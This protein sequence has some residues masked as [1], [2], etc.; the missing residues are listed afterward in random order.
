MCVFLILF[1]Q[2]APLHSNTTCFVSN[3]Y[4][5]VASTLTYILSIST[6][7]T[8]NLLSNINYYQLLIFITNCV[9]IFVH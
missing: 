7:T 5:T 6:I 1:I 2:H 8:I 9:T 3:L 4:N